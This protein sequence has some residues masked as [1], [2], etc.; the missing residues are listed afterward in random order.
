[1][2]NFFISEE[3]FRV[4][5]PNVTFVEKAGSEEHNSRKIHGI[6]STQTR[7]RQDEV[8]IAKG[9]VFDDFMSNGHFN[10]NHSQSTSAIV[11][12]PE[13]IEYKKSI[14]VAGGQETE[15][16]YCKGYII[17]GTKRAD[18]IWELAKALSK[19]PDRRLGFSI[20]GKILR[21][22]DKTI[23]KASIKNV[24]IT[25][26]PVNT[27]ATWECLTKSFGNEEWA[28]K[29]MSAGH[30]VSPATQTGGGALRAEDLD[31]EEKK[32]TYLKKKKA[33]KRAFGFDQDDLIK[34][35]DLVLEA[36]PDFEEDAAAEFVK[37]L[38]KRRM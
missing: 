32:Q 35:F 27:D 23:E 3:E 4:W 21:R 33:L 16:W 26:C 29:S 30:G 28:I 11:G 12:Y 14:P 31:S 19:T 22:K 34:A 18:E 13:D 5:N 10:D 20:E 24:A 9:L 17:K 38:F 1:M 37:Y 15:G 25:N 2:K 8:V 36:R 7:D 6:M